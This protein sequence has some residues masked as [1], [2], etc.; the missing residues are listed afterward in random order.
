MT[1]QDTY[2]VVETLQTPDLIP[3]T[4]IYGPGPETCEKA[5]VQ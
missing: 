1:E 2:V 4:N 5:L 3:V